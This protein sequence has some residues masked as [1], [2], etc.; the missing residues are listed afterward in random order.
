MAMDEAQNL[1]LPFYI[2]KSELL[3]KNLN[4]IKA[5]G[6]IISLGSATPEYVDALESKISDGRYE[7]P[8]SKLHGFQRRP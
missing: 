4:N 6:S 8:K 2:S 3:L 5:P 1:S 7:I